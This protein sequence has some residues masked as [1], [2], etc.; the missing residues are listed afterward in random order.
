M[1]N[2]VKYIERL[3]KAELHLHIEG[4]F[5]PELMFEIAARNHIPI[6]YNSVEELRSA[7]QFSN[8]QDFL[9][10]Y[11]AGAAVLQTEEDF[12][13]LTWAYLERAHKDHVLHT[14]IFFDPQTHSANGVPLKIVIEGIHAA[15]I[16]GHEKLGITSCLIMC[17]LRH[18]EESS[19]LV[20]LE[21]ALPYREWI[22]AVGLDSSENG[23]PPEK[24][25]RVFSQ[26]REYGFLTVAHAGEEGTAENIRNTIEL[27]KVARI[28][29]GNSC[30]SDDALV[31]LLKKRK[32]PLTLCPI[33]NLKLKI[34]ERLEDHPLLNMLQKGLMVTINSDDPA[35][36]GGYINDNYV[37][38]SR[39]L[40]LDKEQLYQIARN[41]FLASFLPESTRLKYINHLNDHHYQICD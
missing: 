18:L 40:N 11:Y 36:F 14:E 6:K 30:L 20:L 31:D 22:T 9:D 33:S 25:E 24:F 7:Y 5:E 8:L 17:F 15:L 23:N 13:D 21:E 10:I 27:L 35:Y 39:A 29:H 41:S 19:A 37:A 2:L 32:I 28:D 1:E 3:P 38:V 4:T 34:I 12:Y 16:D 26:A